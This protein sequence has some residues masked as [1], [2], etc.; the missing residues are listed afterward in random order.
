MSIRNLDALFRPRSVVVIGDAQDAP[1]T[2]LLRRLDAWPADRRSLLHGKRDGWRCVSRPAAVEDG[3]LAVL[4]DPAHGNASLVRKLTARGCRALAWM[5]DAPVP[6]A[7]LRAGRETTLRILGPRTSGSAH[8]DGITASAWAL[9]GPGTTALIAQSRSIASA[10]LDWA[11]GHAL[12]FSWMAVTGGEADVDVSDLLD[13]AALDPR[14]KAV[15]LQVAHISSARKFM[16]AA[17]ACA[18]AKPVVVLQTPVAGAPDEPPQ[19]PVMSAAFGRAG[20]V[21]VD[22]VTALFSA[23]AALDRVG[24]SVTGRVAVIGTG[25]GVCQL[26]RAALLREN[27]APTL[28]GAAALEN[29]RAQVTGAHSRAEAIDIDLADDDATVAA[30]QAALAAPEADT[31]MFVRSPAPGRDDSALA[32]R[33]V[34]AGLRERLVVVFLGQARAAP[35]LHRCA[36]ARIAAF[37]SVEAAARALRYRREHRRTQNLL[38]QTPTLDPL[39]HAGGEPPRI[40]PPPRRTVTR[41]L[42][43]EEAQELLGAYGLYPAAWIGTEGRGLRVRLRHHAELGMH[44]QLRLDPASAAAPTAFALPPLD[45]VLTE[46]KLREAGLGDRSESPPGLRV[47]DYALAVARLA[48]LAVEQPLLHEADV[49]L[50]PGDDIAEVG[51]ARIVAAAVAVPERSRLALAPYPVELEHLVTLRD[52]RPYRIRVIHPTDETAL[53]RML[54]QAGP[55]DIRLRFFRYIRQFTHTMAAR[56][57]QIDYDREISFVAVP[58]DEAEEVMGVATLVFDPDDNAAEF[59]VLIRREFAGQRLGLQLIRDLLLYAAARGT[60]TVSGDVL[61]ENSGMLGL[62]RRLG[63]RREPHPDDPGCV[64]I[65]IAPRLPLN[66][67]PWT[68]TLLSAPI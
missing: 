68:S 9:P 57:T 18:R 31:V 19:D 3:E 10:A 14:T 33:L 32:R 66:P 24:E 54:S 25:S 6:P 21:E 17:R 55:E 8:A 67:P 39:V 64:R 15:V 20:L 22:R 35:A 29:I 62:A 30:L 1:G 40:A 63:F 43:A 49:R 5:A 51:R 16:S 59:A 27:L 48:Q 2:E 46:I 12:G 36:E 61:V 38:M 56:M 45:D 11:A 34:G 60:P 41:N 50:V 4:L 42:P 13:Y 7:L 47:R 44:L 58:A 26:A 28:L 53:I 52:G 65:T 23:L 37:A